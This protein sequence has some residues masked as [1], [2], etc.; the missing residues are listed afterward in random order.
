VYD[1]EIPEELKS[2]LLG[3]SSAFELYMKSMNINIRLLNFGYDI[4]RTTVLGSVDYELNEVVHN[5]S[6]NIESEDSNDKRI[7]FGGKH[8]DVDE[9]KY[10][11]RI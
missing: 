5:F 3:A 2:S 7:V 6:I 1:L 4:E 10:G 8:T 9:N 11:E